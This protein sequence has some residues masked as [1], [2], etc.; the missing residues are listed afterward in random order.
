MTSLRAGFILLAFI[1]CTPLQ[2]P[3][4]L[5]RP[6]LATPVAYA[7][8]KRDRLLI[9]L[10][11]TGAA[12]SATP[13]AQSASPS[14]TRLVG[15][16]MTQEIFVQTDP[17][18]GQQY[19]HAIQYEALANTKAHA[20][21]S[22]TSQAALP[23]AKA[24]LTGDKISQIQ[25]LKA[26]PLA[27]IDNL[28]W[29]GHAEAFC[30]CAANPAAVGTATL[31]QHRGAARFHLKLAERRIN[32]S[33]Q[34]ENAVRIHIEA[35]LSSAVPLPHGRA[36][37]SARIGTTPPST[38]EGI[39]GGISENTKSDSPVNGQLIWMGAGPSYQEMASQ[40]I[41]EQYDPAAPDQFLALQFLG[42]LLP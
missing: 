19:G 6:Q 36:I 10:F 30:V 8:I 14:R 24:F 35:T 34:L 17:L 26:T 16:A 5:E 25:L 33:T 31:T 18:D 32:L 37:A 39:S 4:L 42:Q 1:G 40:F 23:T 27:R 7:E 9:D 21:F 29:T 38:S 12:A 22:L 28:V 15:P 11:N 41:T 20:G 13:A 2:N 3:Y